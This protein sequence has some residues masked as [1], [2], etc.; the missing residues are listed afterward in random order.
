ME[1]E[2]G[3]FQHGA[4]GQEKADR[5]QAGGLAGGDG[6]ENTLKV[7]G[8]KVTMEKQ[9]GGQQAAVAQATDHKFFSSGKNRPRA[10]RMVQQ[11]A[12]QTKA[13]GH[14]GGKEQQEVA[15]RIQA[16][17]ME[18]VLYIPLGQY[19]GPQARRTNIVD[20]IPSP[21]PVFWNVKKE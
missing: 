16:H 17:N 1:R 13:G 4:S 18:Q 20:M 21:V 2:L 14:P 8:A 3:G 5:G 19:V 12:V 9:G 15:A 10:L 6:R 11:Q 7:P